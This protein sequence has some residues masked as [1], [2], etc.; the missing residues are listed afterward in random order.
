MQDQLAWVVAAWAILLACFRYRA[1]T[2]MLFTRDI[3]SAYRSLS[4]RAH[5]SFALRFVRNLMHDHAR[6]G[7]AQ[8]RA[9]PQWAAFLV[10]LACRFRSLGLPSLERVTIAGVPCDIIRR[11]GDHRTPL[12]LHDRVIVYLH[13][14][15]F[16]TGDTLQY[17]VPINEILTQAD[18]VHSTSVAF[19]AVDYALSPEHRVPVA[20]E[21]VVS[22]CRA[23]DLPPSK[24]IIAGDSAG[25]NLAIGACLLLRDVAVAGLVL[26]SPVVLC[27][28]DF[29]D[30]ASVQ[31]NDGRDWLPKTYLT[32][33]IASY[34]TG[35]ASTRHLV[36]PL[37]YADVSR[38][39]RTLT[40]AGADEILLD[41]IVAFHKRCP[42]GTLRVGRGVSH[43]YPLVPNLFDQREASDAYD[44]ICTWIA[45][46]G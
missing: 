13:G 29:A 24:L 43:I 42:A 5:E 20:V 35:D 17:I 30:D 19:V 7:T 4:L 34:D 44:V 12:A 36:S 10:R 8:L 11:S 6:L 45:G 16:I 33:A 40:I 46:Q 26:I 1:Q 28:P 9:A 2:L 21:Q 39:P 31:A 37:R 38:L 32:R 18:R 41:Q 23:L 22:V 25:G 14:G 3:H 15:G 27:T